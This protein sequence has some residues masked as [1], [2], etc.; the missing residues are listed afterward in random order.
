MK[1]TKGTK[2]IG[3]LMIAAVFYT[4]VLNNTSNN[5]GSYYEAKEACEEWKDAGGTKEV[6]IFDPVYRGTRTYSVRLCWHEKETTQ[7]LGRIGDTVI[8]RFRY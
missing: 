8:E 5:Y 3:C 7:I 2:V 6:K 4:V 1:L